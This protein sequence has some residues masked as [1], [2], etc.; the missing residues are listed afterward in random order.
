[1]GRRRSSEAAFGEESTRLRGHSRLAPATTS[2]P[3]PA[4]LRKSEPFTRCS[5]RRPSLSNRSARI[6]AKSFTIDGEAVVLGSDGLSRFDDLRRREAAY[7]AMLYA[8][9][10]ID[11]DGRVETPM[12]FKSGVAACDPAFR[13]RHCF[14]VLTLTSCSTNTSP[15]T[16]LPCSSTLAG[17]VPKASSQ[18]GWTAPIDP[19]RAR[20]GSRFAIRPASRCNRNAARSGIDD[21][22]CSAIRALR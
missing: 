12:S 10:L 18:S 8:F 9:D 14:T 19:V 15:E 11:H 1:M 5:A 6:K 4:F 17:L 20:R 13:W 3:A 21:L 7:S 22:S 2:P 16:A